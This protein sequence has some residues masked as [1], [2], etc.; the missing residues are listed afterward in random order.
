MTTSVRFQGTEI[1]FG[2]RDGEAVLI[3]MERKGLAVVP[4]GCRGGGCGI[5]KVRVLEGA[6]HTGP[7]SRAKVSAG[8]EDEGYALACRLYAEGPLVLEVIGK[9]IRP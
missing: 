5:C 9:G 3:A 6:Y 2:V 4:V 8:E 7:M 1:E